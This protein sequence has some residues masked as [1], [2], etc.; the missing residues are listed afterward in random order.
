MS[1]PALFCLL[2]LLP[3]TPPSLTS[4]CKDLK[5]YETELAQHEAKRADPTRDEES[6][7]QTDKFI[8]E[9]SRTID[10]VKS[11]LESILDEFET[12]LELY[13]AQNGGDH[14][15]LA[16]CEVYLQAKQAYA[17]LPDYG[18]EVDLSIFP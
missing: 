6:H 10:H 15:L 17:A 3:C 11:S 14:D 2:T 5:Y 18:L 1:I 13:L 4:L 8:L 16:Q 9:S 12:A 7:R